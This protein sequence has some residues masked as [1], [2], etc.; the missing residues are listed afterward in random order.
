MKPLRAADHP[1]EITKSQLLR[2]SV[3]EHLR[4]EILTGKLPP[5]TDIEAAEVAARFKISKSPVRDA[6]MYLER[7]NLVI[8]LPRQGY[9]VASIS[10]SDVQ[11]MF[12]LRAAMER[13]GMER[14]VHRASDEDL[15]TLDRFRVFDAQAWPGGFVAYNLAFHRYLSELAK[16][17]RMISQ[18][19][20]LMEQL[21]RAVL[22]SLSNLKKGKPD[23]MVAEHCAIIDALQARR[24]KQAQR[25]VERHIEAAA[26]RVNDAISRIAITE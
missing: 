4:T 5:G 12:Q 26:K 19:A 17:A 23:S 25:L 21:E 15:A 13:A 16:N 18:L 1:A 22:V 14:I 6:L 8:T 3:Y 9:R 7:E 20:D 2:E 11:D 24:L 10:L